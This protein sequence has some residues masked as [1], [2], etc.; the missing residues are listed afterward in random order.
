[1]KVEIQNNKILCFNSYNQKEE[2]KELG[3]RWQKK[4]KAWVL[5]HDLDSVERFNEKFPEHKLE[6]P[7]IQKVHSRQVV[8]DALIHNL[9]EH[10][11]I[12]IGAMRQA[13]YFADL[14]EPGTGKTLVQIEMLLERKAFPALVVCPK[15]IM[16]AV[17]QKQISEFEEQWQIHT[18]ILSNGSRAI[19][20]MLEEAITFKDY[21]WQFKVFIINYEMVSLVLDTLLKVQWKA[22]ILDEST[23]IKSPSAK[24]SKAIMKLREISK[25]RSIMTGT[26]AP[27]GLLDA[28]NQFRWLE[29]KLFGESYYAFRQRYFHQVSWDQFN[30]YPNENSAERFKNRIAHLSVQHKKRDCIDL[31]ALVHEERYIEMFPEQAEIYSEMKNQFLV[32]LEDKTITAPFIITQMMKLRQI[33]SGFIY[34]NDEIMGLRTKKLQEL[35]NILEEIGSAKVIVFTHFRAS[36]QFVRK[37]YPDAVLFTDNKEEALQKFEGKTQILIAPIASAA[38]G[39]NLQYCSNIIFWEHDFNLENFEQGI[40]RIERIGQKNKMTVYHILTQKTLETW[41]LKNLKSKIDLNKEL[42]INSL[43]RNL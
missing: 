38:H 5:T 20:K 13:A 14:S 41:I 22:I 37:H 11:R 12:S 33:A 40:Q 36:A 32:Q 24:R 31:P 28:F 8:S 43:V 30:W 17:W 4:I 3:A 29:P 23:R 21:P 27:N 34:V 6:A 26:L 39:L 42:D 19:K 15:S 18:I 1:M 2:L 16:E 7:E 10:Q 35:E 25:Y 9:Y